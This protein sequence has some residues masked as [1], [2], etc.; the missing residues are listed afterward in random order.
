L[1]KEFSL[2]GEFLD[3]K[4]G[5][6]KEIKEL[7]SLAN[8]HKETLQRLQAE[9][10]NYQKRT[11][12]EILEFRT[13]AN[14]GIL[15]EFL[16]LVDSLEEGLKEAKKSNN[17]E[18]EEGFERVLKQLMQVLEKNG[19]KKIESVGKKFDHDLHECMLMAEEHKHDGLI[20]EEF[21]KGYTLNGKILR[22][23]KVKVN[24][25]E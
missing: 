10:E 21:Q 16:P 7:K 18:M 14:A 3:K 23:A 2:F 4:K 11:E 6:E 17:K 13:I 12:K 8:E 5:K 24:K 1:F 15:E 22:P 9:F 19:I 25:K 20:L